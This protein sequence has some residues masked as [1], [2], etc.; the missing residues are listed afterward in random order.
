MAFL[1]A[2]SE[3]EGVIRV[4]EEVFLHGLIDTL[5]LVPFLF[6][7]YL[8]MEFIE[9]RS[10]DKTQRL[11]RRAGALGPVIGGALGAVP[12]CGFSAAAAN[13]YA[14]R[15]IT[16]GTLVAVFLSTS[17]EMLPILITGDIPVT[18]V[19]L[20]LLYKAAAGILVGFSLDLA[21]R[22]LN[23]EREEM[24]IDAICEDGSTVAIFR[25]GN[26]AF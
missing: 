5:K 15:V 2:H 10:A 6:L 16:V 11:V 22:L 1:H 26:W 14:G 19:L 20:I 13:L 25:D 3:G 7:T 4:L 12:Q 18:T 24:N 23:R 8:L 21:L 17:D 9:H